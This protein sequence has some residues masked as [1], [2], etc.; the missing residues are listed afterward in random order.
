MINDYLNLN[1][2]GSFLHF[3]DLNLLIIIIIIIPNSQKFWFYY[4]F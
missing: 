2:E 4:Y 1:S 3:P